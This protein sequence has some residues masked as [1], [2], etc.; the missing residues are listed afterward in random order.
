MLVGALKT[1]WARWNLSSASANLPARCSSSP[2]LKSVARG[3]ALGVAH[4]GMTRGRREARGWPRR[5]G[6]RREEKRVACVGISIPDRRSSSAASSRDGRGRRCRGRGRRRGRRG[7]GGGLARRPGR[8]PSRGGRG[9]ARRGAGG[10]GGRRGRR[11]GLAAGADG[12]PP[13]RCRPRA[14]ARWPHADRPAGAC[15]SRRGVARRQRGA[16]RRRRRR[17]RPPTSAAAT[18]AKNAPATTSAAAS[19]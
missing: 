11:C 4:L 18:T 19:T 3:R 14:A 1:C 15:R 13:V 6:R 2:S 8:P 16:S 17:R 10:A 7:G 9:G 12:R 5:R